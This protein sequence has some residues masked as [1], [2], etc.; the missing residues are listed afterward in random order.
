MDPSSPDYFRQLRLILQIHID[1]IYNGAG[2]ALYCIATIAFYNKFRELLAW[3]RGPLE[4]LRLL[5]VSFF[6]VRRER[7]TAIFILSSFVLPTKRKQDFEIQFERPIPSRVR[8]LLVALRVV[9]LFVTMWQMRK[10][11]DVF[12]APLL[13]LSTGPSWL[14]WLQYINALHLVALF[15]TLWQMR[16]CLDVSWAPLLTLLTKPSCL[17]WLQYINVLQYSIARCTDDLSIGFFDFS[18]TEQVIRLIVYPYEAWTRK[19]MRKLAQTF[20]TGPTQGTKPA[21]SV[22]IFQYDLL[23]SLA[24]SVFSN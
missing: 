6:F 5:A 18:I 24:S 15:V 11:S 19:K 9:A 21:V 8:N 20:I 13:A 4:L 22:P 7:S 10:S 1:A 2:R 23:P 16:E 17:L 3:P 14:L 12:W